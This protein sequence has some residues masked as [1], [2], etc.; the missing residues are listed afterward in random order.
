MIQTAA[1]AP[2]LL[3]LAFV[4]VS[5]TSTD[6]S[7]TDSARDAR[8]TLSGGETLASHPGALTKAIDQYSGDDLNAFASRLRFVGGVERQR[9]CR[10]PAACLGAAPQRRTRVRVD[11]VDG[12]DSLS[13]ATIP[14]NGV[15]VLRA[16]NRGTAV[17]AKYGM[18]TGARYDYFL[19]ILPAAR[20]AAPTWRLEELSVS[21]TTRTHR[22]VATGTFRACNHA[23]VRGARAD[24][25]TCA[26][27][28]EID[29]AATPFRLAQADGEPPLWYGCALGC[30]TAE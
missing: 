1:V 27:A 18:R 14:A 17:D 5:C 16:H 6:R 2:R 25:K 20:G 8:T 30:C 24:F 7:A 19:I 26:Q 12:E 22:S 10:G 21:G 9:R 13:A 15:I 28:A 11:A 29:K 4:L 3:A 23:Y